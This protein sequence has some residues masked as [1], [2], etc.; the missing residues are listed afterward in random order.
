MASL[1]PVAEE[2]LV[3]VIQCLQAI[4]PEDFEVPN[5][6][7]PFGQ[8]HFMGHASNAQRAMSTLLQI[9]V[10]EHRRLHAEIHLPFGAHPNLPMHHRLLHMRINVLEALLYEDLTQTFEQVGE[11]K[12]YIDNK[13]RVYWVEI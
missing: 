3:H 2:M 7:R 9:S 1:V 10:A 13:W 11:E 6:E 4:T 5:Q 8:L 12:I